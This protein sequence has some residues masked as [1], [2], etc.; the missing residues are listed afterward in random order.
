MKAV[1]C[2][3]LCVV[4][5]SAIRIS[6]VEAQSEFTNFLVHFNKQ[7]NAEE[8]FYR[9]NVF[10]TALMTIREHNA[11][12]KSWTMGVNQFADMT[13]E[14]FSEW[15]GKFPPAVPSAAET[16]VPVENF[17]APDS[18][19]WRTKGAVTPVKNQ[20]GC[21]SCWT[22]SAAAA[23]E[24]WNQIKTGTMTSLSEQQMVDCTKDGCFGCQGGWPF[25][26]MEY[27]QKKGLCSEQGYP[28]TGRDGTCKDSSCTPAVAPGALQGYVNITNEAA[29]LQAIQ[30]GPISI[31]VEA[32]RSAFQYYRSGV[33]DDAGCGTQIDHAITTVGYDTDKTSGKKF[34]IVKNSWG[35]SWG[36]QGYIMLVRDKNQ[37]GMSPGAVQPKF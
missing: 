24:G 10:R 11:K 16:F 5:A 8:F 30:N 32:D 31:L 6:E 36:N 37:C 33:L 20:G 12:G 19:D 17:V 14:E 1:L 35:S 29:Q 7:Y 13:S 2:L 9:F 27:V 4:A 22:F 15:V 23:L 34:W 18:L 25:K 3:A 28:Y 21:G 26:C